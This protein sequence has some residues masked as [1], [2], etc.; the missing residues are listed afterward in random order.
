VVRSN[1]PR[2]ED[3]LKIVNV[4]VCLLP[5]AELPRG[6]NDM[7]VTRGV[8]TSQKKQFPTLNLITVNEVLTFTSV[9]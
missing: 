7:F 4:L 5:P 9:N 8:P 2:S 6:L 1:N 3:S